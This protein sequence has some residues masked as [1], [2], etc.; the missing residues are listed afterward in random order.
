MNQILKSRARIGGFLITVV[1]LLGSLS[2]HART[3]P[4]GA[5]GTIALV[6]VDTP[7]VTSVTFQ[8]KPQLIVGAIAIV[9]IP[10]FTTS[11][12]YHVQLTYDDGRAEN[13]AIK[14]LDRDYPEERITVTDQEH[15]TPSAPTL[16]RVREES[17]RMR[18]AYELFTSQPDDLLPIIQPVEGRNSGVFGSRRF[19]N[20]QPRNPHSGIDWAAPTGTPIKNPTPGTVVV[21]GDFFFNGKTVL[22]DHGGG[23][24]SMM[25]HLSEILVTEGQRID[26]GEVIGAVGTTGRSTGPHLHWTVSLNGVRTDPAVFMATLNALHDADP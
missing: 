10:L 25:C 24:V 5:H 19:F 6:P 18:A 22:I 3:L 23:F 12:E 11:G 15:V 17:A 8:E 2:L 21:V 4:Q 7:A 9:A 1:L 16:E 26:R 20:D 13:V 14:V